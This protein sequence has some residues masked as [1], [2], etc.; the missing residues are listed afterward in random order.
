MRSIG[1]MDLAQKLIHV[2]LSQPHLRK[3]A[4]AKINLGEHVFI[5]PH[6]AIRVNVDH[7]A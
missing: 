7:G 6:A 2:A 3:V 1:C 5:F 4:P